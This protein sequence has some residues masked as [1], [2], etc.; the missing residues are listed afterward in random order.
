MEALEICLCAP[1]FLS[2]HLRNESLLG[3]LSGG[4][5]VDASEKMIGSID[6]GTGSL[7][8]GQSHWAQVVRGGEIRDKNDAHRGK[9]NDFTFHQFLKI[10]G[11]LFFVDQGLIQDDLPSLVAGIKL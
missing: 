11:Y 10:A 4:Q 1:C 9:V 7:K 2:S 5:A 6:Q 8:K 3:D